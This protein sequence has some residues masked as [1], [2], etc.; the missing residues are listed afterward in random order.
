MQ[1]N[2]KNYERIDS[3]REK[4]TL[5][6]FFAWVSALMPRGFE[7]RHSLLRR[8]VDLLRLKRKMIES[9]QSTI[10]IRDFHKSCCI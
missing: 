1:I 8:T 3:E 6:F 9:S 5:Y 2:G 10:Y 4:R 7:F